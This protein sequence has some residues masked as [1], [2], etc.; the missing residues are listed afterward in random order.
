MKNL[1][2]FI[3]LTI[4][5]LTINSCEKVLDVENL[6]VFSTEA[7]WDDQKLVEAYL[8]DC[9]A[10]GLPGGWPVN[11]GDWADESGGIHGEVD[12]QTSTGTFKYWPY[13]SIRKF[14]ILLEEID[15]GDLSVEFKEGAKAQIYFL[16]AF[17]YFKA[18][19][20]HGGV[21][22]IKKAQLL[23]DDLM[24]PRSST[25]ECFSFI[26]EDLELAI[27]SLPDKSSGV[28]YGRIDKAAALS[29]KG[30]VLLFKASPQFNPTNPYDNSYWDD[31][32]TANK[33][34]KDQLE[35]WGYGLVSDYD[36]IF[37][38]E[39]HNEAVLPVIFMN[40]GKT[41]GRAEHGVRPLSESR[42]AT[43]YDQPIWELVS[44][45][46]MKD[47]KMPGISSNYSYDVQSYWENR[48]PRFYSTI[49]YNGA[50]CPLG[51]SADRRQYND[52][53]VGNVLDGFCPIADYPRTGFFCNKGLDQSLT[54][55]NAELNEVDWLEIR[56]AEVLMNY[57]EA[58]NETGH[59]VE[60]IAVLMQIRER[61]GIEPG[62]DEAYGLDQGMTRDEIRD[63]IYHERYIEFAFEGKRFWDLRRARRL[64]TKIDNMRKHGL[65]PTLKAG[66]DP[67]AD[68]NYLPKDFDYEVREPFYKGVSIM[69]TPEKYYFFPILKDEMEKNPELEQNIGWE[70][71]TFDPTL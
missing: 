51:V 34:A 59:P 5:F 28:D 6:T 22:I 66:L 54:D 58:A 18:V 70:G 26:L 50:I 41:N 60:A 30:R 63:A 55:A 56:F 16:R 46:P 10:A 17:Q 20:H 44:S 67:F 71:G 15:K 53:T 65:Q 9:Y 19:I 49:I 27:S 14:N 24:V 42:N 13:N 33:V 29:F 11:N 21:P 69:Y 1:L 32:Y 43:G 62:T 2:T 4:L 39:R 7:V 64:H 35:A 68:V 8:A 61:A 12:V 47:G 31:A 38:T 36:D 52:C 37:L 40:P 45:Y 3:F 25:S 48:D 57:A 23:T